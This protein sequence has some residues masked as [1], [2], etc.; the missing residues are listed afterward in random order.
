M[1]A[2]IALFPAILVAPGFVI[3]WLTNVLSFR[4][5]A[6][7]VKCL[8][9]LTLSV[10]TVPAVTYLFF[11]TGCRTLYWACLGACVITCIWIGIR[12]GCGLTR[13]ALC[14]RT[15][16]HDPF[17]RV[18]VIGA[19]CWA[20]LC[21]AS[22]PDLQI[23]G[24]LYR[25]ICLLDYV[26]HVSV[27]D[28]ITRT[29]VPPVNPSFRDGHPCALFYYYFWFLLCSVVSQ[30]SGGY[31]SAL[32]AVHAG[33]VW[34]GI[35]LIALVV[36][37]VEVLPPPGLDRHRLQRRRLVAAGLLLLAGLDLIAVAAA[38]LGGLWFNTLTEWNVDGQVTPWLTA[39]FWVP[40]HVAAFAAVSM[41]FLMLREAAE[42]TRAA[43]MWIVLLGGLGLASA[44]GMSVW[45]GLV[46]GAILGCWLP[47][48]WW[49]GWRAEA[50]VC[51]IMGF[52]A[53]LLALPLLRDLSAASQSH[54]APVAFAIRTFR[55]V[56]MVLHVLKLPDTGPAASLFEFAA[57]PYN[58]LTGVGFFL[59]AAV[60]YWTW[61]V[62]Q[63]A[64]LSRDELFLVVMVSVSALICTFFRSTL[65]MNDLGWRGLLFAQLGLLLWSVPVAEH[66]LCRRRTHVATA[67]PAAGLMI[68][69]TTALLL[70]SCMVVGV[71]GTV[72][73]VAMSRASY[74]GERGRVGL[75]LRAC[76][77]WISIHTPAGCIVQANPS[78][79]VESFNSLYGN[80]QTVASDEHLGA[81]YGI[82]KDR[83]ENLRGKIAPIFAASSRNQ[84]EVARICGE[85]AI[86]VI[87][88]RTNDPVWND[89][90]G[91]PHQLT[92]VFHNDAASV[93]RA[94]QLKPGN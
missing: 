63:T 80:R 50:T 64:P 13:L 47:F 93:F 94:G 53:L 79:V 62:R 71:A 74:P 88:V 41:V 22:L 82:P 28:A 73:D 42:G 86:D 68:S 5:R 24:R 23:N 67:E 46:G 8:L 40:H 15:I 19:I 4:R 43:R 3:G 87:V 7:G 45:V 57:L 90:G 17:K 77:E 14:V 58:Y 21:L 32:A 70:W 16:S 76:Y 72:C 12:Q 11:R 18:L 51:A 75:D 27:T 89:P 59:L 81:L 10:V 25:N 65:R 37:F 49:R 66:L 48:A 85:F 6:L 55:P 33:T 92:P 84:A 44:I 39:A 60:V 35:M 69:R 34:A 31:V 36:L 78:E 38:G 83:F 1:I 2:G 9:S 56:S 29:G 61:R 91:W 20:I 30:L 26:K 52:T 54:Q